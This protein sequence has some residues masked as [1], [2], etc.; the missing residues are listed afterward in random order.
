MSYIL[1]ALKKS[2]QER[3]QGQVPDLNAIHMPPEPPARSLT[4]L[5]MLVI[6]LLVT[7]LAYVLGQRNSQPPVQPVQ[8]QSQVQQPLP[9]PAPTQQEQLP[10]QIA[11]TMPPAATQTVTSKPAQEPV[12]MQ[13]KKI[14]KPDPVETEQQRLAE[15]PHLSELPPL[16][17]QSIPQMTFAGHVYST[18]ARQRSV[19]INGHFMSEGDVLVQGLT[20]KEITSKGV[21]FDYNGQLFRMDILQDWSFD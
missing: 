21:I 6:F 12:L 3:K 10:Q 16:V 4:W 2:E 11:H 15:I 20:L 13:A 5:Y 1:D 14:S 18:D 7:V 8:Q 17:Q 19:I 9:Q